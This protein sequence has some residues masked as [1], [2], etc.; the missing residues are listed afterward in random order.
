MKIA[1]GASS[2]GQPEALSLLEGCELV[3]NPFG[4]KLTEAETIEHLQ[5]ASGLLAGLEPLG[6]NVFKACPE[7][8]AIARIGIGMDNVDI[9]AAKRRGIKVSNTP[10]GPTYAVAEMTLAALLGIARQIVPANA[11]IHANTWKKRMGFSLKGSTILLVGYGRIAREFER[12]LEPFG[13]TICKYDPLLPGFPPQLTTS[14]PLAELIKTADIISLHASGKEQ[15]IGRNEIGLMK[16]GAVLLNSARGGLVDETAVSD[17]LKSGKLS[18]YWADVFSEEPYSGEL[19]KIDSALLTP[20][21][22]TYTTL[23]RREMEVQAARNLLED[24][25]DV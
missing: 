14:E 10:D 25:K 2:F 18:W 1:V 13:M 8:K 23:C 24:L 15:I 12:L 16:D 4:R 5:G 20:H 9:E 3:L 21:I 19:A 11:D 17:A 6:E 7:L 22:S